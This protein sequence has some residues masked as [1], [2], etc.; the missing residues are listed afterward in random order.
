M[1][2]QVHKVSSSKMLRKVERSKMPTT[3]NMQKQN[4][5]LKRINRQLSITNY[6]LGRPVGLS[7]LMD[8]EDK[9][10]GMKGLARASNGSSRELPAK[11]QSSSTIKAKPETQGR[12]RS[13]I[14]A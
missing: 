13:H 11:S 2:L 6:E 1:L 9:P 3:I 12:G 10:I 7:H 4:Y 14:I 5:K 8:S